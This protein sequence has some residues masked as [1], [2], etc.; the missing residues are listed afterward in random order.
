MT[1]KS[2]VFVAALACGVLN[3]A[4]APRAQTLGVIAGVVEDD[5]NAPVLAARLT[6]TGS[7][8]RGT[9]STVTDDRGR[10]TFVLVPPGRYTLTAQKTGYVRSEYGARTP[11]GAGVPIVLAA[12]QR[13][14]RL[15][16]TLPRGG[17]IA[18]SIL[19]PDGSPAVGVPVRALRV[20]TQNGDRRLL[21]VGGDTSDDRG[22]YRIYQLQPGE[23][24]VSATPR[25]PDSDRPT[26]HPPIYYPGTGA[27]ASAVRVP[28]AIAE[29]RGGVDIPLQVLRAVTVAGMVTPAAA[30][31]GCQTTVAL[32]PM[33]NA[34]VPAPAEIHTIEVEDERFEVTDV[35]PGAY[36]LL[37]RCGTPAASGRSPAPLWASRDLA[38][39]AS[40][41]RDAVLTLRPGLTVSGRIVFED[42]TA[43]A[44]PA[45]IRLS[46][47]ERGVAASELGGGA[48][49]AQIG[50]DGGFVVSGLPPGGYDIEATV[51]SSEAGDWTLDSA[52]VAG[53]DALDVPLEVPP[54]ENV[55]GLRLTFSNRTQGVAGRLVDQRNQ[56]V[57]DYTIVAFHADRRYWLAG[58]RRVRA[59]R[60]ATDGTFAIRGLPPGEY[61]LVAVDD[62]LNTEWDDPAVLQALVQAS[63]PITVTRGALA[64]R[65][66][67][68][69]TSRR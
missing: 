39:G 64:T 55:A 20:I 32:L 40:D 1:D 62:R 68:V 24:L 30:V 7:A 46:L 23:Y 56:P 14:E 47:V 35:V 22:A 41:I 50:P 52:M 8:L 16:V 4:G 10:F 13:L 5:R 28:L 33:P 26:A 49:V 15:S 53:Q 61:R 44:N 6:L 57:A 38:V 27:F 54:G 11:G 43:T 12:G 42:T 3:P 31:A 63:V 65:Q 48:H 37:A 45:R 58:S 67:Q 9:R 18:G 60:A 69:T 19:D 17:V 66:L 29:E 59:V 51:A 34:D 2:L 21:Q 36:R 25:D